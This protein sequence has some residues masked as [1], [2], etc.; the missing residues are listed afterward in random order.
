MSVI[1]PTLALSE[2]LLSGLVRTEGII[3]S[4]FSLT[5]F[6]ELDYIFALCLWCATWVWAS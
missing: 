5:S 4:F 2:R 6:F 1:V 3:L